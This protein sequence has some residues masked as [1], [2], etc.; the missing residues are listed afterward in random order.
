MHLSLFDN[1]SFVYD[2]NNNNNDDDTYMGINLWTEYLTNA[3]VLIG[4]LTLILVLMLIA[5]GCGTGTSTK[6][7]R[8]DS[9]SPLTVFSSPLGCSSLRWPR[10]MQ[11]N[12][13]RNSIDDL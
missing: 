11:L 4:G 10:S 2:N 7:V 9:R 3:H 6:Q 5:Y 8:S 12:L 1:D 13:I